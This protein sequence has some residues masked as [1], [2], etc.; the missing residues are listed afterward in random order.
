[1]H[2]IV[3][4]FASFDDKCIWWRPKPVYK[5]YYTMNVIRYRHKGH[6]NRINVYLWDFDIIQIFQSVFIGVLTGSFTETLHI[7]LLILSLIAWVGKT[8][9][10]H[11]QQ[12]SIQRH[13]FK[14]KWEE[15]APNTQFWWLCVHMTIWCT[16]WMKHIWNTDMLHN[17]KLAKPWD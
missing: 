17:Q 1:M 2:L 14:P 13:L 3:K 11:S 10:S 5:S 9:H 15:F 6:M 12:Q 8:L 7:G 16:M 4:S